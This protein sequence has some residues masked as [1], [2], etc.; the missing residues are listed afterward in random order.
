MINTKAKAK[1]EAEASRLILWWKWNEVIRKND[2]HL[3]SFSLFCSR[4]RRRRADVDIDVSRTKHYFC[5]NLKRRSF[6]WRE[7]LGGKQLKG[8]WREATDFCQR[9]ISGGKQ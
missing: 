6:F 1:A 5:L 2:L 9:K 3:L 7:G 4:C 8:S